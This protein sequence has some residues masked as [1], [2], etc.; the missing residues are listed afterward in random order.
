MSGKMAER[1]LKWYDRHGRTLPF[2][3]TKDPYRIWVSEIM[4]QQTRTETVGIYFMNFMERFPDVFALA[5]AREEDVLKM[6]EGLGYYSRA[7][8]LHKAAQK[9]ALEWNGVFPADYETL[10][11][12]PGV[13]EYTA[14]AIASIG[15]DLPHPAM[16]GNLT[17]VF[18]RVHGVREDVNIPSVK[19]RLLEIA[20][21]EMPDSRCGDFNQALMDLGATVCVP[22][23]PECDVCPLRG[24][25]DAYREGDADLLPVKTAKKAPKQETYAVLLIE[26]E[27][28]VL[29]HKRTE[30]L[31]KNMWVFPM[32]ED[33]HTCEQ[34]QEAMVHAGWRIENVRRLCDARHVFTHRI[35]NMQVWHCPVKEMPDLRDSRW[36]DL[37]TMAELPIPTAVKAARQ[38]AVRLMLETTEYVHLGRGGEY[39]AYRAGARV[40]WESWQEAN[41]HKGSKQFVQEHTPEYMEMLMRGHTAAGKDVYNVQVAGEAV[42]VLILDGQENEICT[43]YVA[44]A[45]QKMGIGT[46]AVQF[47]VAHLDPTREM[48]VV[49]LD[50]VPQAIR[51]YRKA[52]FM[53]EK[54]H[55]LL[56]ETYN[57]WETVLVRPAENK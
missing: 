37:K 16:D 26:H 40:Y 34:I 51:M 30:A 43:L 39:A 5:A 56:N 12:L 7:R 22:G 23:T 41:R 57:V 10:L 24:L 35:W 6:W 28:K 48:T 45:V 53:Q 38:E 27:G 32:A 42:G 18:S 52:G 1:L 55:R 47:A 8:N 13:G 49:A 36:V 54:A 11:S 25:C 19:R 44:P 31:L 3:G 50:H 46:R 29:M 9:V 14:A 33:V 17:R 4:L 21:S 15:F 2:R 20:K